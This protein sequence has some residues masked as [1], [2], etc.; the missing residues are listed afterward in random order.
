M[1]QQIKRV[2]FQSIVSLIRKIV[3]SLYKIES[4]IHSFS[5]IREIVR[6]L[7]RIENWIRSLF[8]FRL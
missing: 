2:P 8:R 6:S 7:R 5:L 3:R 4:W 1:S